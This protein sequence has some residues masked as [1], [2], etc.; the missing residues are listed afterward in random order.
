MPESDS[1][2]PQARRSVQ[3]GASLQIG[4]AILWIPQA[5]LLALA[6]GRLAS[7]GGPASI[8]GLAAGV[9]ALGVLRAS[10]E[11]LGRRRAYAAARDVLSAERAAAIGALAARSPIDRARPSAGQAAS[12]IAEQSEAVV[13]YLARFRPALLRARLVPPVI[14]LA[15][16]SQSWAAALVLLVAAPLIP[17]FMALIGWRAQAASE[18]QLAEMG[19]M[20]ALL[21]DRLRGLATIRAFGAVD[22][23]ARRLRAQAEELRRRTM[24]VLRIATLSSAVLELFS[25]LGVAMVAVWV[26]FHLLGVLPFGVWGSPLDLAQGMFVL[27]LAPAFFAPLR[28]LAAAWHDRAAGEAALS[29]LADLAKPGMTLPGVGG[30]SSAPAATG[31]GTE[32]PQVRVDG[33]RFCHEGAADPVF[34]GLELTVTA[35]EH[36]ALVAPS[37]AGKSTLLALLAGLAHPAAGRIR[38]GGTVLDDTTAAGLRAGMAWIGQ[39]PHVFAGTLADNVRLGRP[40]DESDVEAALDAAGLG[41]VVRARGVGPVG[42]A[43]LGL[44][45]GEALRLALARL[46]ASRG[47]TLILADEPT[48][49]LDAETAD[50]VARALVAFARGRTLIVATHDPRLVAH[51]DRAITLDSQPA[52]EAA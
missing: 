22:A 45:G 32:P 51:M 46:A 21:L 13:P 16:L 40:I 8:L 38:I 17:V 27:L 30:V 44:S 20:N 2:H 6:L 1:D 25:A 43:G 7:G 9:L 24:A 26:G 34:D 19:G 50:D 52:R 49:H 15:V 47:T 42:E 4:A 10:L 39:H 35:G 33:V 18:A 36:V 41:A 12:V 23:T 37:G 31:P 3:P 28:D 29:A 48:A 14:W 5:A 11:A